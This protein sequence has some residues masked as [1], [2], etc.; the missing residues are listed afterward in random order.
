MRTGCE[1]LSDELNNL[2]Q[3]I[4]AMAELSGILR[5]EFIKNGFS[6]EE[7]VYLVGVIFNA[8]ASQSKDQKGKI[9]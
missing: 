5:E 2:L 1:L 4:G 7:A 8:V 3:S 6:R 9:Q